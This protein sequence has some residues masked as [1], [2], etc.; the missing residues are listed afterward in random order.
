VGTHHEVPIT[1]LEP[2]T[3]YAYR[4][5]AIDARGVVGWRGDYAF[6]T[7]PT[8]T[9]HFRFAVMSDS[10]ASLGGGE[11]MQMGANAFILRQFTTDA[12]K[13]GADFIVFP[14]DLVAGYT[15]E[16]RELEMQLE[17]WK[18]ATGPPHA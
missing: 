5:G 14:G 18:A 15:T 1:G 8:E 9:R 12:I 4:V 7:A 3:L 2:D 6:R 11:R 16:V 17:S 13:Q 10:R